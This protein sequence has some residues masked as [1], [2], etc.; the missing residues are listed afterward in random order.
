[1]SNTEMRNPTAVYHIMDIQQLARI[2]PHFSWPNYLTAIGQQSITQLNLSTPDFFKH[3]DS[4]LEKISLEDWK[5]YLRWQL[6]DAFA[7]YLSKPFVDQN[8]KMGQILTG[9]EKLL[10]RWKRVVNTENSALGFAIGKL[11]VEKYFPPEAKVQ[12]LDIINNIRKTL[13]QDIST[14]PWMTETTRQAAL[15]K[16]ALMQ[17]RVGYPETWRDYSALTV[18]RGPYV[19]NIIRVNQFLIKRDLNKIGK[20]VDR[21]EWAMTPQTINAY[22]DPSMNNIN[23]PAGILQPPMFD[24]KAPAAANYG[25]IGFIIGHEITHGFDDQ[26]AKFDGHG[27]LKNWWTPED[28]KQF[29]MATQCIVDQFNQYKVDDLSINGELVLGEATADLGGLTL[30]FKAFKASQAYKE[31]KTIKGITPE[32]QFFLSSAHVWALNMRPEQARN[33]IITDPHPPGLYRVNGT[34]ANMPAFQQA[35]AIRSPSVMVNDKRC[36][37]W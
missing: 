24:P 10:P 11:Y 32:Q 20:P 29:K 25:A 31:A 27:N 21:N 22:Y 6:L 16:L 1:M 17:E 33:L 35:F 14:L 13:A 28:A 2:T 5:P 12:V 37:V 26:G 15:A 18:D 23:L 19:L 3:M 30:A 9:T 4:L 8:F 7:P 36:V 34:L